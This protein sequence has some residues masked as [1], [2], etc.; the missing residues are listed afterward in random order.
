MGKPK[1]FISHISEEADLAAILKEHIA[2]DFLNLV[3][4]FVSSDTESIMAG[5]N[6]LNS[7]ESALQDAC[8]ELILWYLFTV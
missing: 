7:I 8:I 1:I 2:K 4:V 6:W 3:D 5:E